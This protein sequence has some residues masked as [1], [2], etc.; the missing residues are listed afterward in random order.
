M[1]AVSQDFSAEPVRGKQTAHH[2]FAPLTAAEISTTTDLIA[3][4]W[5]AKVDLRFKTIT[6]DEPPKSQMVPYLEAEHSGSSL[7]FVAR[8][9][10]VSYY[11]RNTVSLLCITSAD[12]PEPFFQSLRMLTCSR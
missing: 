4:V 8:K 12:T 2:P 6:L 11:I 5:P 10:F 7:P 3:S 1:S 9:S